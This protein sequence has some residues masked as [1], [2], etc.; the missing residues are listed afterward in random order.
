MQEYLKSENLPIYGELSKR[1]VLRNELRHELNEQEFQVKVTDG[2]KEYL[3][4][5]GLT[6]DGAKTGEKFSMKLKHIDPI[7]AV[8]NEP[9]LIEQ[10]EFQIYRNRYREEIKIVSD[11]A[12]EGNEH[13]RE[14]KRGNGE[15]KFR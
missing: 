15:I 2:N 9:E 8:S 5:L 11:I 7:Y 12:S 3:I 13:T 14:M 4:E 6:E 10:T 1:K